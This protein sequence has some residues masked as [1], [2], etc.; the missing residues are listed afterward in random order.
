MK[1]MLDTNI[2]IY[3]IR[4]KPAVV[5]Q[6]LT[7]QPVSDIAISSITAAE[8]QFGVERSAN[9][10]QNRLALNQFLVPL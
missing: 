2:C 1:Y 10:Q 9:P 6:K 4:G 8:L 3:V 7:S 5:L